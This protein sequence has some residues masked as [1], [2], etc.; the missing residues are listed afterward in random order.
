[1]H[2]IAA[3]DLKTR[4]VS[5]LAERLQTEVEAMI[6]VRGKEQYVVMRVEQYRYLREMELEAALLEVRRD[7][8]NGDVICE[9]AEAHVNRVLDG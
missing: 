4:G 5:I 7:I 8:A 9:S 6:T 3:N 2:A 1:M